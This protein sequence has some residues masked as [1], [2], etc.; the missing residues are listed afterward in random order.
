MLHVI[1][2]YTLTGWP[3]INTEAEDARQEMLANNSHQIVPLP[4]YDMKGNLIRPDKYKEAL[5]GALVRVSFTLSHWY[6]ASRNPTNNFVADVKSI[7]VLIDPTAP[8][9]PTKRRTAKKEIEFASP[10]RRRRTDGPGLAM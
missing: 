9:S 10:S 6:I 7:R 3:I 1:D 8:K 4:A 2:I 5:A